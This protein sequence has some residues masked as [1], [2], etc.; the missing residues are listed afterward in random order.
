MYV[1]R[2]L[3]VSFV[4]FEILRYTINYA[5]C[6]APIAV[7]LASCP[8]LKFIPGLSVRAVRHSRTLPPVAIFR[9]TSHMLVIGAES[10]LAG[11]IGSPLA[12]AAQNSRRELKCGMFELRVD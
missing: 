12:T 4:N 1:H 10:C 5:G 7:N 8:E 9:L 3:V 11:V 2:L 6:T